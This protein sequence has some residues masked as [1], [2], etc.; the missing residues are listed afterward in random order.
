MSGDPDNSDTVELCKFIVLELLTHS[1]GDQVSAGSHTSL[2]LIF[3][4]P[5]TDFTLEGNLNRNQDIRKLSVLSR[6]FQRPQKNK[7]LVSRSVRQHLQI[8]WRVLV[9]ARNKDRHQFREEGLRA[10]VVAEKSISIHV[11]E[12][13]L[14]WMREA[15][16]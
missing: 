12:F 4:L 16:F 9:V 1:P 6:V 13:A 11:V 2:H 10:A 8:I 14:R 3:N 15:P 5:L 7:D